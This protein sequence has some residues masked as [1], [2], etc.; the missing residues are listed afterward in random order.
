MLKL[1]RILWP[2]LRGTIQA[3]NIAEGTHEGAVTKLSDAAITTRNLLVKVGTDSDHIAVCGA[4]DRP[5]GVCNDEA[6]AAEE[7][8]NVNLLGRNTQTDLMVA[9]E[10]IA[11]D[12]DVYTAAS[13]K[14]QNEPA[15]AGTYYLVGHSLGSAAA[16]G[17]EL[18]VDSCHPI[19]FVVT[20]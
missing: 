7:N 15:V 12:V 10:A 8:V 14:I 19:A 6:G 1:M 16:V 18:E 2:Q 3:A 11:D 13:G 17:D 4:S 20:E 5:R 9:S